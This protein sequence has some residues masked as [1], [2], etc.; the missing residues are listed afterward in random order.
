MT[1]NE[2]PL[3]SLSPKPS[4]LGDLSVVPTILAKD[5]RIQALT[6]LDEAGLKEKLSA[7]WSPE[8]ALQACKH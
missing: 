3:S 5:D 8:H 2:S 1:C 7:A 6:G 4:E